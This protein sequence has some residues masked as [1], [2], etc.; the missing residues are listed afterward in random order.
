MIAGC[1][2][3]L[4]HHAPENESTPLRDNQHRR[5]LKDSSLYILG[6]RI[7]GTYEKTNDDILRERYEYKES[8]ENKF[9]LEE[10]TVIRL[11]ED[12]R[13]RIENIFID[14]IEIRH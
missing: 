11:E 14:V 9:D 8:V 7:F 1:A 6:K 4:E 5:R 3:P 2:T 12:G 13:L 10:R